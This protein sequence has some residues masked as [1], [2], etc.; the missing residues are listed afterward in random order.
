MKEPLDPEL[1]SLPETHGGHEDEADPIDNGIVR[2]VSEDLRRANHRTN[3]VVVIIALLS[4]LV[5]AG[6]GFG[7]LRIAQTN[8]TGVNRIV[9][10]TTPGRGCYED[11]K[12]RNDVVVADALIS[13]NEEHLVIECLLRVQPVPDIRAMESVRCKKEAQEQTAKARDMLRAQIEAARKE[14]ELRELR[15]G[16]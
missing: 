1:P 11:A 8:R 13:L 4:G 14:S 9:D 2:A 10:C 6:A 16:K 3:C 12:V 7:L 15:N 5:V